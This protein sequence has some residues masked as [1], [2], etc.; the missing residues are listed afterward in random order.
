MAADNQKIGFNIKGIIPPPIDSYRLL[1]VDDDS[2]FA[3]LTSTCLEREQDL[4]D[5]ITATSASDGMDCLD[6]EDIDC[7]I[8]DY[9]MPEM[10]GLE[11][12]AEVR[13]HY[14]DTPFILFTGKGSEEIASEAIAAG[15]TD[16]L[17]KGSGTKQYA[18]LANRIL[19]AIDRCRANQQVARGFKAMETA[20]EG[21]SLLDEDGYFLYVN[22]AFAETVGYTR[23]ELLNEHW[24]LLYSEDEIDTLYNEIL[25]TVPVEGCWSGVTSY[26]RQDDKQIQVDHTLSH[27]EDGTMICLIQETTAEDT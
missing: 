1:H 22:D 8:S 19:N 12:L 20:R 6:A 4:F 23:A 5:V 25:P 7:I 15:V 26:V 11:F 14:P 13:T 17:Q 9:D 18:L 3:N 21:I 10:D 24:G 16:Y 27:T 2:A